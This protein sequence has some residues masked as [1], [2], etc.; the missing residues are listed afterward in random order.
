M[1]TSEINNTRTILCQK[2][3]IEVINVKFEVDHFNIEQ[4]TA[5]QKLET[6]ERDVNVLDCRTHPLD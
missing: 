5:I 1:C 4:D 6:C 3:H 2:E